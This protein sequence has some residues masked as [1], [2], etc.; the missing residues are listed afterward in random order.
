MCYMPGSISLL[1]NTA[2]K[3]PC[4]CWQH[5]DDLWSP[6]H[7]QC[8]APLT[9]AAVLQLLDEQRL[10]LSYAVWHGSS[11]CTR[12]SLLGLTYAS[13]A[14]ITEL[15]DRESPLPAH[16]LCC[17]TGRCH[18]PKQPH[19][20]QSL[21]TKGKLIESIN[22]IGYL[23]VLVLP[24]GRCCSMSASQSLALC[25]LNV[26]R[27]RLH[28][29]TWKFVMASTTWTFEPFDPSKTTTARWPTGALPRVHRQYRLMGAVLVRGLHK[30]KY[31]SSMRGLRLT[32]G[33]I[34]LTLC[35]KE[36]T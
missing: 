36:T 31:C 27:S 33:L 7:C 28:L 22:S 32:I 19:Q 9:V 8:F 21:R 6:L 14:P 1:H 3:K 29:T 11:S 26:L 16:Q 30:I 24:C 34:L 10:A 2:S 5:L 15:W 13:R 12:C 23:Y 35:N 20:L 17:D 18:K 4:A 25:D